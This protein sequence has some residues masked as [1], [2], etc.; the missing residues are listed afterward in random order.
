MKKTALILLMALM[1][2]SYVSAQNLGDAADAVKDTK[3]MSDEVAADTV[4]MG[5]AVNAAAEEIKAGTFPLGEWLDPNYD[6]VWAFQNQNTMLY[7]NDELVYNFKGMISDFKVGGDVSGMIEVKFR[8]DDTGRSY[9]FSMKKDSTDMTMYFM[10]DN[11][12]DYTV[13]MEKVK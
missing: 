6:A 4:E 10:K 13:V 9:T 7:Q 3:E 11:G 12:L 8:C 1:A 2:L 5:D